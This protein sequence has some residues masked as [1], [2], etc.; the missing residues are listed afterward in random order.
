VDRIASAL[1]E[2][3]R[4]D[5]LDLIFCALIS[6]GAYGFLGNYGLDTLLF[7]FHQLVKHLE[8]LLDPL[9]FAHS[10][11]LLLFWFLL[12]VVI[13]D[14]RVRNEGLGS[15]V[16]LIFLALELTTLH[17]YRL[18]LCLVVELLD[19]I[20]LVGLLRL[21]IV[22]LV[23]EEHGVMLLLLRVGE[24][25][26]LVLLMA[27]ILLLIVFNIERFWRMERRVPVLLHWIELLR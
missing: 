17:Q 12:K 11:C 3:S 9:G 6:A 24:W 7:C 27:P 22:D 4:W 1:L 14:D 16:L 13:H 15:L 18:L 19:Q 23:R 25:R 21:A 10:A 20:L 26:L 5:L 8:F 2:L